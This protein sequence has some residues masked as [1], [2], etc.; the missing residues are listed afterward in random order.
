MVFGPVA[1]AAGLAALLWS[2]AHAAQR[3]AAA[4][5]I[6]H[7]IIIMQEN[8][9]FDSYF[10]TFPGADGYPAGTCVPVVVANPNRGCVQ[11]FHDPHDLNAGGPHRAQDAM[12]DLDDGI[13]ATKMDGFV[14]A[15]SLALSKSA[16]RGRPNRKGCVGVEDGALRNDVMGYHDDREIPNYWTLARNFVLQDRLFEGVRGWSVPAHLDLVSEWSAVCSNPADVATCVT[17]ATPKKI[18]KT[19]ILP[20]VS[21]FQLFDRSGVS[22][23]YYLAQGNEP[24]CE[25][26]EMT[27]IPETVQV[28]TVQSI[29]NPTPAFA[30]VKSQGA[31]YLKAHNPPIDQ[32]LIDAERGTLPQ[33]SWVV[34]NDDRSEHPPNGITAGM[35][36]VSALVNA[37]VTSPNWSSSAIFLC[38]D[39][40]GGFY[41][42]VAPPNVDRN[43][44]ST[45]IQGFGL[46]V[47]G[48]MISPYARAGMID[49]QML[50]F[51][52]FATFV[53]NVFINGARLDPAALGQPD[54]RPTIRDALTSATF[55]DGHSEP[56]GDLMAEFDFAQP[57]ITPPLLPTHIPV[58]LFASCNNTSRAQCTRPTVA[59]SWAGVATANVPG[60]FTYHV[61][62]DGQEL[63]RCVTAATSCTDKPGAGAHLYRVY[64]VDANG[65]ASPLS[66]AAEAD[67]P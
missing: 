18:G 61:Q 65:V 5:P 2:P 37:V 26:D 55:V 51:S 67:Q 6:Q 33:V 48:I 4:T 32:F 10:G 16:C 62:R 44:S 66:A 41:D 49:H 15:Q 17:S 19:S 25:D 38:W 7:V 50:D 54:A 8:R 3:R 36:Y 20:W 29:W 63:A 21:L 60:P 1:A 39:D 57:A 23:K 30:W 12:T 13:S 42:H 9:S 11:P 43:G 24:D 45:P 22:W 53:E 28:P 14:H 64:S 58:N 47:P 59:L 40:W 27:C 46:R 31:A 35:E 52:S 56:I 34:P